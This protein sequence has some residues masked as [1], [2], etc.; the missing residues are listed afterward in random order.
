[1]KKRRE[2]DIEHWAKQ[3]ARNLGW[4]VR[5]F[6]SPAHKSVPD[7]IFAKNGRLFFVEFKATGVKPTELQLHEHKLLKLAGQDVYV[8]DSR[9]A[10][11][12][13]ID[14][15]EFALELKT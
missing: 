3:L 8:I 13:L 7:D 5:K 1:L 15:E 2:K 9:E 11:R 10:F 12:D 4:W 6:T 14:N